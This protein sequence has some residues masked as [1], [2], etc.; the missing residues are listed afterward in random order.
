[1]YRIAN[2]PKPIKPV[3]QEEEKKEEDDEEEEIVTTKYDKH[4]DDPLNL[5]NLDPDEDV[6]Y[7]FYYNRTK[8]PSIK[9]IYE[10]I[11]YQPSSVVDSQ[12][13]Y[14]RI[15]DKNQDNDNDDEPSLRIDKNLIANKQKYTESVIQSY[16]KMIFPISKFFFSNYSMSFV[17]EEDLQPTKDP[18]NINPYSY[19]QSLAKPSNKIGI[20]SEEQQLLNQQIVKLIEI[21]MFTIDHWTELRIQNL[22]EGCEIDK[23]FTFNG[24]DQTGQKG[25]YLFDN[26]LDEYIQKLLLEP[27]NLVLENKKNRCEQLMNMIMGNPYLVKFDT[28]VFFYKTSAFAF[29]GDF[30]RTIYFLVQNL[31]KQTNI[32]DAALSKQSKQ[33]VKINRTKLL[34]EVINMFTVPM[35]LKRK[36]FLEIEYYNEEGT[37]L[38]PT[39]EFY[40]L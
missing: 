7:E 36:N 3:S 23:N 40:F 26:L 2:P 17:K 37:G 35:T 4:I 27:L 15:I 31:R 8:V 33:K 22:I 20:K 18:V 14:F 34:E 10:L 25:N 9:T 16:D 38:G 24:Q 12:I 5:K 11:N 28:R 30:N 19:N 29:S 1:M 21:L 6:E 32:P 39:L 13:I